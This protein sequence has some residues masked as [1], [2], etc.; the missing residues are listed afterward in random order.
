MEIDCD[1]LSTINM[2]LRR[3]V[4]GERLFNYYKYANKLSALE[5]SRKVIE[6]ASTSRCDSKNC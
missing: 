2:N 5:Y 6:N 1:I 4:L 3:I